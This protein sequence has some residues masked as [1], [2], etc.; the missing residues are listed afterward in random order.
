MQISGPF[1]D[2]EYAQAIQAMTGTNF[3]TYS[4]VTCLNNSGQQQ[5]LI[6]KE[7]QLF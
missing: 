5:I 1:H 6:R 7:I 2:Y 4:T 3:E